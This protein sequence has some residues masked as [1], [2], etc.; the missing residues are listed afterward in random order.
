MRKSS[1][2]TT[3][4]EVSILG[5]R[6]AS[7]LAYDRRAFAET[8]GKVVDLAHDEPHVAY[9]AKNESSQTSSAADE[10]PNNYHLRSARRKR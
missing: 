9:S 7:E 1:A 5:V 6:T 4:D 8:A 10:R 2:H 3:P